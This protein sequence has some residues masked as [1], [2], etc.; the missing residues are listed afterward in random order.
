MWIFR[1]GHSTQHPL[2]EMIEK[3]RKALD[4]GHNAAAVLTDLSKAFDCMNHELL[5][6]K[7][8]AYGLSKSALNLVYS[9]LKGRSQNVNVNG[10]FSSWR[11]IDTGVPQG[12][13][14]G[15]LLFNIYINDL[16]YFLDDEVT[17]YADDTT[18]Y[19]TGKLINNILE[20][21]ETSIEIATQWFK[22]N[23][24]RLNE[25]TCE[26]LVPKHC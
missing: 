2:I 11:D 15:P 4:K 17:N 8:E 1:K 22:D 25:D 7:L 14:L 5:I 12:S 9:Y 6:A 21:L 26:L 19:K 24:F 18:P 10:S 3:W 23:Y 16:F 13:I 20:K